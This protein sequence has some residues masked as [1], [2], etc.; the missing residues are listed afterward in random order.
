MLGGSHPKSPDNLRE[1]V[2]MPLFL[3]ASNTIFSPIACETHINF[4]SEEK[5][6]RGY[7]APWSRYTH[8]L[9]PPVSARSH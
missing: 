8:P 3:L 7:K 1:T 4:Y 2:N 5:R 9:A 6:G